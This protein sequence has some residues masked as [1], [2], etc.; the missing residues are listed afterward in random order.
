METHP[1]HRAW[2]FLVGSLLGS[3]CP[4]CGVTS[5]APPCRE[6]LV[7]LDATPSAPGA[8]FRDEGAAGRLVRAGKLGR[9]RGA[10]R[11][12]A[13]LMSRRVGAGQL[14]LPEIDAVTWVPADPRRRS[15]RGGHLPEQLGRALARELGVPALD[16][17][18][19]RG[20]RPQRGLSR[21]ARLANVRDAFFT[22]EILPRAGPNVVRRVL[23]V[24]DVRTTGA[25]F[26]AA[27]AALP[28]DI[29]AVGCVALVGVDDRKDEHSEATLVKAARCE[30]ILLTLRGPHA[31]ICQHDR[32]TDAFGRFSVFTPNPTGM[33]VGRAAAPPEPGDAVPAQHETARSTE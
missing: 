28:R 1:V 12:C 6:C 22:V 31:D 18:R 26:V 15:H 8:V 30:E 2:S 10:G 4:G 16:L 11:T 13:R 19:R 20:G 32:R 17:L 14:R 21:S 27:V 23:L 3:R 24:D 9:W 25:T 7:E 5:V 33:L 29:A